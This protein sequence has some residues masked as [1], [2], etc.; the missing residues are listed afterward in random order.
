MVS[1]SQAFGT[2]VVTLVEC[3]VCV[4]VTMLLLN[5]SIGVAWSTPENVSDPA[6]IALP[7]PTPA[8]IVTVTGCVPPAGATRYQSSVAA[9]RTPSFERVSI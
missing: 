1:T 6:R 5:V 2:L 4:P 3:A 9:A 8:V 7:E